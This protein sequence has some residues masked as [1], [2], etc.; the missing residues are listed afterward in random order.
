MYGDNTDTLLQLNLRCSP[1]VLGKNKSKLS[2]KGCS[3]VVANDKTDSISSNTLGQVGQTRSHKCEPTAG[4]RCWR[5]YV[6]H[7]IGWRPFRYMGHIPVAG[8]GTVE[9]E[10]EKK[11]RKR[12]DRGLHYRGLM[13][14][15]RH[16]ERRLSLTSLL[17][18]SYATK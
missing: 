16:V 2:M 11:V 12:T 4:C 5:I 18:I 14:V 6:R 13:R 9:T 17:N 15:A 3:A 8:S 10:S 7:G 1:T